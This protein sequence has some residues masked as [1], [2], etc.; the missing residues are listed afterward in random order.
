LIKKNGFNT[1]KNQKVFTINLISS[2]SNK[3]KFN[4]NKNKLLAL[5]FFKV[6]E[7]IQNLT[8]AVSII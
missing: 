2:L 5:I 4:S 1:D 8:R 6:L 3:K 7:R